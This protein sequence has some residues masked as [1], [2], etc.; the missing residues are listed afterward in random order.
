M[1]YF[2][3]FENDHSKLGSRF[4]LKQEKELLKIRQKS[5]Y[6]EPVTI[7]SNIKQIKQLEVELIWYHI[8]SIEWLFALTE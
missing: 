3:S 1:S 7:Q 5:V 8:S 2:I 4:Y 6:Q